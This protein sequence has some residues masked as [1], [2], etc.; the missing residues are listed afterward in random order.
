[1]RRWY[2]IGFLT[3]ALAAAGVALKH[4]V[5]KVGALEAT[6]DAEREAHRRALEECEGRVHAA[7]EALSR[8]RERATATLHRE[9]EAAAEDAKAARRSTSRT[10]AQCR[11][12]V[13]ELTG[14]RDA[15]RTRD[16]D[17]L[18]CLLDV[19]ASGVLADIAHRTAAAAA[20]A[21]GGPEPEPAPPASD[22][23]GTGFHEPAPID[24]DRWLQDIG[25]WVDQAGRKFETDRRTIEE[26]KRRLAQ[27]GG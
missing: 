11:A 26:A 8:A 23:P 5:G 17:H 20:R 1:M 15:L 16:D 6:L 13:Q 4:Q 2:A 7:L 22:G 10:L 9:R 14:E 3:F 25:R 12:Q 27:C 24:V 18:D 21:V 19:R